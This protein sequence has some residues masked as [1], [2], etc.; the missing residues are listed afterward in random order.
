[1]YKDLSQHLSVLIIIIFDTVG[2]AATVTANTVLVVYLFN[3]VE[4]ISCAKLLKAKLKFKYVNQSVY[5]VCG[6]VCYKCKCLRKFYKLVWWICPKKK[7]NLFDINEIT[8]KEKYQGADH[9]STGSKS[10]SIKIKTV[11]I[12]IEIIQLVGVC[13]F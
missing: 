7:K 8:Y 13:V 5:N 4:N 9:F 12:I 2:A 6:C 3:T 11:E 1:M 10:D